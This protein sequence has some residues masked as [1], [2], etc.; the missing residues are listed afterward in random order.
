MSPSTESLSLPFSFLFL[1]FFFNLL[2]MA[3]TWLFYVIFTDGGVSSLT[4]FALW[5]RTDSR[6]KIR[7]FDR[8]ISLVNCK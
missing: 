3:F 5:D 8:T 4:S 2:Q 1:S 7:L 6:A